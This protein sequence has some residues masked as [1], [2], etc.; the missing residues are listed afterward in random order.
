MLVGVQHGLHRPRRI[1]LNMTPRNAPTLSSRT[2]LDLLEMIV[3]QTPH[4]ID[5][6]GFSLVQFTF[7]TGG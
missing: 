2:V 6:T 3:D 5:L 4:A 1:T 7:T